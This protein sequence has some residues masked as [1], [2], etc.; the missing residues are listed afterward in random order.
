LVLGVGAQ[1]VSAIARI[2]AAPAP[3]WAASETQA[4][5]RLLEKLLTRTDDQSDAYSMIREAMEAVERADCD[6][7][8]GV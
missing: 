2:I 4:A 8:G 1:Q 7:E 3:R 6:L 5:Y